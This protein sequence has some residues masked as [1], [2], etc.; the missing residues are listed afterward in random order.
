MTT[1]VHVHLPV[2]VCVVGGG[3]VGLLAAHVLAAHGR[4]VVV[5]E[6][7]NR[8]A[9]VLRSAVRQVGGVTHHG[10]TKARGFG[11]GGTSQLWGGQLWAWTAQEVSA[12]P[13]LGLPAWPLDYRRDLQRAYRAVADLLPLT[14]EQ[15]ELLTLGETASLGREDSARWL[16]CLSWRA[17]NFA[18][19]FRGTG[20]RAGFRI[21]TDSVVE[22]LETTDGVCTGVTYVDVDGASHL[23]QASEVLVTAGTLGNAALL[24][25]LPH[26]SP[27][28]G[29]GFMD[30]LSARIGTL[31]VV[32]GRRLRT[33]ASVRYRRGAR[34]IKRFVPPPDFQEQHGLPS[35]FAQ[36][37]LDRPAVL[38]TLRSFLRARQS[39][40]SIAES[41][42]LVP[43]L[44][45][46]I[47]SVVATA[48]WPAILGREYIASGTKIRLLVSIEQLPDPANLLMAK[49]RRID[50]HWH[51]T[52]TDLD[53]LQQYAN[54]FAENFDW[55][56]MGLR[57]VR[58]REPVPTDT[59][60]MMGGTR[61]AMAP[62]DGVVDPRGRVFG[63]QNL[64]VAGASVFPTGGV[65]NPTFT[66]CALTWLS[67]EDMLAGVGQ[68]E[69]GLPG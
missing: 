45:R 5:L 69:N 35:G 37:E 10:K 51:H 39:R 8:N 7:G 12:R 17:R 46:G 3:T 60:H 29:E 62:W 18:A 33:T 28:L 4:R 40:A 30:H 59:F 41:A 53:A 13:H 34:F 24:S 36:I 26:V 1:G 57:L 44:L 47:P 65:A 63:Y 14:D 38:T 61:M 58:V 42:A 55:A 21:I 54:Y 49:N 9:P 22:R 19:I 16:T 48:V 32:T 56:A 67:V 2:D 68:E 27:K 15:R 52:A 31:E 43:S 64:R 25:A 11:P 20:G 50:M 23:Q 6:A 66:A